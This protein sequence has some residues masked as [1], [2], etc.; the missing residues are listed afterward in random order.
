MEHV[1]VGS[2][3]SRRR[4]SFITGFVA[5]AIII[6]FFILPQQFDVINKYSLQL[7]NELVGDQVS[8]VHHN[9]TTYSPDH[10]DIL[11]TVDVTIACQLSGEMGNN[12]GKLGH[13]L[14][15]KYWLESGAFYNSTHKFGYNARVAL[16]HQDHNKWV[17]GRNDLLQCFPNTRQFDF[18]ELNNDEYNEI[19]R[20][21]QDFIKRVDDQINAG[22]GNL[23]QINDGLQLFVSQV[24][25]RHIQVYNNASK[26]NISLPFLYGNRIQQMD[27]LNDMFYNQLKSFFRFNYTSCCK[28]KADPDESVFHFRNF[29]QEM[30]RKWNEYGFHEASAEQAATILFGHLKEGD[31]VAIVTR[32]SGETAQEY[33]NAFTSRG[34]KVRVV[35]GQQGTEDF[36]LLMSAQKEIVGLDKSTYLLWAGYLGNATRVVAYTMASSRQ[37]S[38]HRERVRY[39][40]TSPGLKDR[41]EFPILD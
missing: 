6:A 27:P 11:E 18:S 13:C 23:T 25:E 3:G 1:D 12:L 5:F 14:S 22:N 16:R 26:R 28:I 15:L 37:G 4:Q 7:S 31:K 34:L 21:Q 9:L 38:H 40:F 39:N 2:S 36:C 10:D 29:K 8:V 30:P 41:F 24:S 19:Y 17:R 32:F 33:K 35:D 20:M